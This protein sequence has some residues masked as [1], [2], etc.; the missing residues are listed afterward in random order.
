[1]AWTKV[2]ASN[3]IAPGERQVVSVGK[4]NILVLNHENQLYAV[5]NT[6]PHLKL[7]I[8]KGKIENGAIVCPFHRS[9]FDLKSGEVTNWCPWPPGVGKVLSLVSQAKTLPV[10]PLRVEEGNIL[11][12]VPEE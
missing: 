9:A 6:C 2:L 11:I 3:A 12:D 10:F 1:M 7:P 5:E 4:R 8:K